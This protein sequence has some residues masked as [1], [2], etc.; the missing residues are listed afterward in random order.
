MAEFLTERGYDAEKLR[1]QMPPR[2]R[3]GQYPRTTEQGK[4]LISEIEGDSAPEPGGIIEKRA[5]PKLTR[6]LVRR[7]TKE[8]FIWTAAIATRKDLEEVYA[9]S[10]AEALKSRTIPDVRNMSIGDL[11]DMK[12]DN[13]ILFANKLGIELDAARPLSELR[14]QVKAAISSGNA[15][16]E[17]L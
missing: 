8:V 16:A 17:T 1:P 6:Y 14:E 9:E 10:P 7:A 4:R 15:S 12:K 11:E 5:M 3:A 13:L 2:T